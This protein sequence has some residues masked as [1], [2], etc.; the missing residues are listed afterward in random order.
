MEYNSGFA[1]PA[2]EDEKIPVFIFS[3]VFDYLHYKE[4]NRENGFPY[5]Q[6]LQCTKGNGILRIYGEEYKINKG[7]AFLLP[8]DVTH[9]YIKQCDEWLIDWIVFSG[10]CT[11]E[12]FV[13]LDLQGFSVYQNEYSAESHHIIQDVVKLYQ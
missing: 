11:D 12:I 8:K 13:N 6:F 4:V 7:D 2:T 1:R 9:I 10:S 3:V 5:Y